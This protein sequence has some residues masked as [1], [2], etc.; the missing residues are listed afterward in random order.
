M[1]ENTSASVCVCYVLATL[2]LLLLLVF[3]LEMVTALGRLQTVLPCPGTDGSHL[4]SLTVL[5]FWN[6][7]SVTMTAAA[8]LAEQI[9]QFA[10]CQWPELTCRAPTNHRHIVRC[11]VATVLSL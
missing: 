8:F 6:D 11:V 7:D 1:F 10:V 4:E 9:F 3:Q 5:T 2:N